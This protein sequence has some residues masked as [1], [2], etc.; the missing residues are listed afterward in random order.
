MNAA[1]IILQQL[2]GR[3]FLAMTGSKNLS[4]SNEGNTLTMHLTKNSLK[5]KYLQITLTPAD[6]YTMVFSTLKKYEVVDLKTI[7]N[8]YCDNI[9]EIFEKETGLYTKL[10]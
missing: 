9:R 4:H 2:G 8:V 10:F 6:T 1:T 3:Q 7:E 5:A